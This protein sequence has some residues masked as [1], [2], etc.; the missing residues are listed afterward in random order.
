MGFPGREISSCHVAKHITKFEILHI[1]IVND[2]EGGPLHQY[3]QVVNKIA[4]FHDFFA[5]L[6][7]QHLEKR[8]NLFDIGGSHPFE[9]VSGR[10][11]PQDIKYSLLLGGVNIANQFH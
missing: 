2:D 10:L 9:D 5:F 1:L 3:T 7:S 11:L 6:E 4:G 8:L